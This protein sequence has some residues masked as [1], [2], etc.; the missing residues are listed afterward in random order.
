MC[1]VHYKVMAYQSYPSDLT[2]AE[3][4]IVGPLIPEP[5][6]NGRRATIS[7]R[8]L[9]N[10]MFARDQNR[11]R[12]GVAATRLREIQD[13]LSLLSFVAIVGSVGSDPHDAA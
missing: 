5:K 12:L 7:R 13:G 4:S 11:M 3:W 10:A 6:T 9:L 2:N 1:D 8:A